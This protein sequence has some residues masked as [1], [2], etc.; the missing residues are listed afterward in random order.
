MKSIATK[1]VKVMDDCSYVQKDGKNSF[2]N[3]NYTSAANILVKVNESLVKNGLA[4]FATPELIRFEDVKTAKGNTEHLATVKMIVSLL[5]TET[6]E[7]LDIVGIG[8]GQDVGDKAVMK[9]QTAALK[10]AWMLTLNIS[11]G[12]DPE[13]DSKV[14]E[15]MNTNTPAKS[16]TATTSQ[17]AK[18]QQ[19]QTTFQQAQQSVGDMRKDEKAKSSEEKIDESKIKF[20]FARV[21]KSGITSEDLHGIIKWK[22]GLDS[23]KDLVIK[24]FAYTVNN[25]DALWS[26]YVAM[27]SSAS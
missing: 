22:F 3:Y 9:A 18:P 8:S 6:D 19:Q 25:L 14:D 7:N 5:D 23:V 26:E 27:R 12:D 20:L 21:N 24:D 17:P 10:Y 13:A 11:T 16:K 15:R 2:H 1:L 4:S